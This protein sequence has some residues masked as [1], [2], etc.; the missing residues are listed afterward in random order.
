[1]P[2]FTFKRDSKGRVSNFS[3]TFLL[4]HVPS[5]FGNAVV[6]TGVLV[7]LETFFRAI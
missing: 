5:E 2:I 7:L 3:V 4:P 6:Y 1:M